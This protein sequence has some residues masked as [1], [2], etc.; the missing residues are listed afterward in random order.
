M[1]TMRIEALGQPL[2]LADAPSPSPGPGEALVRVRACGL[3]FADTL[4]AAGRYQE[5]PALPFAPGIEAWDRRQQSALIHWVDA[6]WQFPPPAIT[7]VGGR[8]TL[9][10]LVTR[11]S[12]G[13]PLPGWVVRY[14]IAGGPAAGF[15]PDGSTTVEVLTSATGEA[16]AEIFQQQPVPGSN[17]VNIQILR[18]ADPGA[19]RQ[20]RP[21]A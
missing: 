7:P 9:T 17:V 5:K 8:S 10:T 4:M 11:Q 3:N 2:V 16:P 20:P 18:P 12:D 6:Q 19:I 14:E 15:A 13:A 1:R 21:A